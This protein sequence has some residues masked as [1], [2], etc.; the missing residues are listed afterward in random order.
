MRSKVIRQTNKLEKQRPEVQSQAAEV[1][2]SLPSEE[3][4]HPTIIS[5]QPPADEEEAGGRVKVTS[6]ADLV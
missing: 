2:D 5:E 1:R 4:H 6:N 3:R